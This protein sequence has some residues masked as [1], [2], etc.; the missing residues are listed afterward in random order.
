MVPIFGFQKKYTHSVV[1][2]DVTNRHI[3]GQTIVEGQLQLLAQSIVG[4]A[5]GQPAIVIGGC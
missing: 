5:G 3:K 1:S 4:T 2:N